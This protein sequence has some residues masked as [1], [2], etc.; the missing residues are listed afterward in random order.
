MTFSKPGE[1]QSPEIIYSKDKGSPP[2]M[3]LQKLLTFDGLTVELFEDEA[4]LPKAKSKPVP[5]RAR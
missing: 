4:S 2:A 3:Q 1:A 5:Q